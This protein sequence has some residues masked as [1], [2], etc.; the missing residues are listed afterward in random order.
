MARLYR[1]HLRTILFISMNLKLQRQV[2]T[3]ISTIGSLFIDDIFECFTLEDTVRPPGI[4]IPGATA[5]SYGSYEV[6]VDHSNRFGRAMPHVLN[7]PM[8]E[9]I[10]IHPGNTSSDTEGCILLGTSK[11]TDHIY[12]SKI[13]FDNFF[14]KLEEGLKA[15]KVMIEITN[16]TSTH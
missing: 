9:G 7:V 14:P 1:N 6:I 4:K 13:A 12:N 15:G 11:S 5:I 3:D 10:R 8:F 16:M 2:C